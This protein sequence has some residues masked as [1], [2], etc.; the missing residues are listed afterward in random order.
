KTAPQQSMEDSFEV[1]TQRFYQA[2][3]R[4][5]NALPAEDQRH[6]RIEEIKLLYAEVQQLRRSNLLPL[7]GE[8]DNESAMAVVR[9]ELQPAFQQTLDKLDGLIEAQMTASARIHE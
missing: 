9:D 4:A 5:Q 8:G 7:S 6:A 2:L 1:D 3:A